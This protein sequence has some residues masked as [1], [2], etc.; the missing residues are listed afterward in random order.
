VLASLHP[1]LL[2]QHLL[3][4]DIS[5]LM[6][7]SY[8]LEL[9]GLGPGSFALGS[10]T[11]SLWIWTGERNVA[12]LP[13]LKKVYKAVAEKD[14]V[15]LRRSVLVVLYIDLRCEGRC[16]TRHVRVLLGVGG[17]KVKQLTNT[18]SFQ[19]LRTM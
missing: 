1:L 3:R 13:N 17:G 10:L 14:M 18:I 16:S 19:R 5:S 6:Y 11:S 7:P 4:K 15:W 9:L 12:A 8:N 2:F